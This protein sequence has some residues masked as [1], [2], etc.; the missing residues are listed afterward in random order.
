MGQGEVRDTVLKC[1]YQVALS[2]YMQIFFYIFFMEIKTLY[3]RLLILIQRKGRCRSRYT[4]TEI[5]KKISLIGQQLT[6]PQGDLEEI[7]FST[8]TSQILSFMRKAENLCIIVIQFLDFLYGINV[9]VLGHF[10]TEEEKNRAETVIAT[11]R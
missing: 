4:A 10:V 2:T 1:P 5:I 8:H 7:Y 11:C 6:L 3:T 9:I